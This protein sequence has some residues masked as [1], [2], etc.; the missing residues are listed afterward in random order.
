MRA[1]PIDIYASRDFLGVD[2]DLTG[3]TNHAPYKAFRMRQ[4]EVERCAS[5]RLHYDGLAVRAPHEDQ[6]LRLNVGILR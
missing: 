5:S 1:D 6:R 3:A 4:I 2:P